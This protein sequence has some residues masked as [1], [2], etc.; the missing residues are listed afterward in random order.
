M[1]VEQR[2]LCD[3]FFPETFGEMMENVPHLTCDMFSFLG[4]G[5]K[6]GTDD[7]IPKRPTLLDVWV[8]L[9][10]LYFRM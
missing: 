5:I 3:V 9:G 8:I 2:F 6:D 7:I 10:D 4:G 1:V